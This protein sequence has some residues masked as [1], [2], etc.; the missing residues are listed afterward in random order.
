[1]IVEVESKYDMYELKFYFQCPII[2]SKTCG[3][4]LFEF[5][6]ELLSLVIKI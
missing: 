3:I 2:T 4:L 6:F 5:E 1:M